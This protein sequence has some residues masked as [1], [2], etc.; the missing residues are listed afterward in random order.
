MFWQSKKLEN[1]SKGK[2]W[3]NTVRRVLWKE[4][5]KDEKEEAYYNNSL[6]NRHLPIVIDPFEIKQVV[7]QVSEK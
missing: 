3:F 2:A 6:T 1:R 4:P 5:R 7:W